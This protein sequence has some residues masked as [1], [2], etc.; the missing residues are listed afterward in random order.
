MT[1]ECVLELLKLSSSVD[2]CKPLI[3]GDISAHFPVWSI[4]SCHNNQRP[5]P[6]LPGRDMQHDDQRR[7]MQIIMSRYLFYF[8]AENSVCPGYTTAGARF[9]A[10]RKR[11][12]WD[13]GCI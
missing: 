8:A 5:D 2:E 10:Q 6:D 11:F 9:S 3:L 1:H 12:L 7:T 4:G 13:R